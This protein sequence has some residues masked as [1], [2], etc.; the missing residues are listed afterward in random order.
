MMLSEDLHTDN[1]HSR[2]KQFYLN[3]VHMTKVLG[4]S[5]KP[6][7]RPRRAHKKSRNGCIRCK[8]KKK[9]VFVTP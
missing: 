8:Q 6:A 9:K 7:Y 3:L 5:F 1:A 2:A 4:A